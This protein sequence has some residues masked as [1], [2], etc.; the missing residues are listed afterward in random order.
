M[1]PPAP[2]PKNRKPRA[3]QA[4]R[5]DPGRPTHEK[6]GSEGK[7]RV[8]EL[9]AAARRPLFHEDD[10]K[11]NDRD[12]YAAEFS[13]GEVF[14]IALL[15]QLSTGEL[16]TAEEKQERTKRTR[17]PAE[18]AA[19]ALARERDKLRKRLE[20]RAKRLGTAKLSA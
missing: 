8:L 1:Y 10:A 9:R 15:R 14:A 7:I 3:E 11:L 18:K 4:D 13:G 19:A 20:R 5:L 12:A 17:S 16:E 6:P 2:T